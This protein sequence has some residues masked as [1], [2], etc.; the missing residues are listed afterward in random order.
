[1]PE[2]LEKLGYT[3]KTCKICGKDFWSINERETCGDAPCDKYEFIGNPATLK[4]YDLHSIQ[5]TFLDFFQ[6]ND[7]TA[8]GRY[9]VLA[10]RWR[11]DVF[12]VGVPSILPNHGYPTGMWNLQPIPW[13]C[14]TINS[15]YDVDN[16]A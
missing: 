3:K 12:L 8:I 5:K 4:K 10:K 6:E 13:Y 7:H 16:L 9:P 14:T 1:M 15:T 11:D 2:K